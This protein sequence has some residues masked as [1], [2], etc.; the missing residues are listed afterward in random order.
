MR[1]KKDEVERLVTKLL[2]SKAEAISEMMEDVDSLEFVIITQDQNA[3]KSS[4]SDSKLAWIITPLIVATLLILTGV[5]VI[6]RDQLSH[7]YMHLDDGMDQGIFGLDQKVQ[8]DADIKFPIRL[9]STGGDKDE[10][11]HDCKM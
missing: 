10:S 11:L 1:Y 5:F 2:Q 8:S 6:M 4:R 9:V 7:S 3:I